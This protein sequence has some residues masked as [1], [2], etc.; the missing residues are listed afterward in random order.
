MYFKLSILYFLLFNYLFAQMPN[1]LNFV[2]PLNIPLQLSGTFG[3][4]RTNHFHSGLDFRTQQKNGL[5]VMAIEDGF[6]SRIKI[7]AFGYGKVIYVD[8][9]N[10][11]TS[12]YAHLNHFSDTIQAFVENFQYQKQSFEIEVFTEPFELAV[13]KGEIIAYSGNT[14]SS[15]GPHLHFEIRETISEKVINPF[16]LGFNKLVSDNTP[17][18]ISGI[19][20]YPLSEA[21][22]VNGKHQPILINFSMSKDGDYF[23]NVVKARDSIGFSVNT[24]DQS[25]QSFGK[26]GVYSIK[27]FMNGVQVFHVSFDEFLFDQTNV[28]NYYMDYD[29]FVKSKQ[30]YQK[31]FNLDG[32][33]I[34]VLKFHKNKGLLNIQ[35]NK[36]YQYKVVIADFYGNEKTLH[37]PII[38][39]D[40]PKPK[41]KKE[42]VGFEVLKNKEY[43]FELPQAE[44]HIPSDAMFMNANLMISAEAN[45]FKIHENNIP[46]KKNIKLTFNKQA[47]QWQP[48]SYLQ[49]SSKRFQNTYER[50]GMITA[51]LR[52]F[53]TYSIQVDTIL[54]TIKPHNFKPE[55]WLSENKTMAF[56][57]SDVGSGIKTF[58]GYI[59]DN[60]ILFEYEYKDQ[61]I[62]HTFNPKRL[63]DG[64]NELKIKVTDN[65]GNS[66]IFETHF[67][68]KL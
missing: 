3:E 61:T 32:V 4:L 43:L 5:P 45:W 40:L 59:N 38:F 11:Y 16:L 2:S 30:K 56:K 29:I 41:E 68:M 19:Y 42:S 44:L 51:Y 50:N 53:D 15:G 47:Y 55:H 6:V 26:N 34:P 24:F 21:A 20:A 27:A 63:K 35:P 14:G 17:P 13:K 7:S 46:L 57:I 23:A 37:I 54:P 28:V 52:N 18:V 58:E 36:T 8:H 60:W 65:V 33:D 62:T 48:Q 22:Q 10:G 31:L 12:V 1:E 39:D 66:S 64:R 25:L 67:F 9:P 49:N